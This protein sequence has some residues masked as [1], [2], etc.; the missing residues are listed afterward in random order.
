MESKS[1]SGPLPAPEDFKA[2]KDVL[3]N[4]PERILAMAEKQLEHRTSL[5]KY[6]VE[7]GVKESTRGQWIGSGLAILFLM[8]AVYLGIKGHES[9]AITIVI[10][11]AS[12][13]AIFVLKKEPK[14]ESK[15]ID[16][17]DGTE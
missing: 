6:I 16:K 12:L 17:E 8:A 5:E 10:A 11:I 14:N 2:Y 4:A 3:P 13:V 7:S 15:E 1:Y 9:V